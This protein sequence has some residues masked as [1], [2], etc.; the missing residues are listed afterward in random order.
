MVLP[1]FFRA[2]RTKREQGCERG[3]DMARSKR[4][5][6]CGEKRANPSAEQKGCLRTPEEA[7]GG[8]KQ[9]AQT[10]KTA[11]ETFTSRATKTL[12]RKTQAIPK[13]RIKA[14]SSP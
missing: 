11:Y 10:K 14:T 4:R 13:E 12:G 9:T 2:W 5:S 8:I 3:K 7:P 6:H 1:K